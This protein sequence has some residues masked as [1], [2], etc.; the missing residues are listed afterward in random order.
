[1]AGKSR[2]CRRQQEAPWRWASRGWRLRR[3]SLIVLVLSGL[4]RGIVTGEELVVFGAGS[5]R[6]V[7]T[8]V[9]TEYQTTHSVPVRTEFGPS[10]LMRE[11]IEKGEPLARTKGM[12]GY[13]KT[14]YAAP[15]A[16]LLESVSSVNGQVMIR[17]EPAPVQVRASSRAASAWAPR[18]GTTRRRPPPARLRGGRDS[19][20]TTH[21]RSTRPPLRSP[22]RL[23]PTRPAACWRGRGVQRPEVSTDEVC[24]DRHSPA[25]PG[26]RA[27]RMRHGR[28]RAENRRRGGAAA[29]HA[30]SLDGG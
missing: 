12:F 21:A 18:R 6:E 1:M 26:R 13:F 30:R 14:E 7:L 11:R 2:A 22:I 17:G 20:R 19:P 28:R 25:A 15:V 29:I 5:L 8:Q 3:W 16:G 4:L 23:S 10:G 9:A 27:R 24:F